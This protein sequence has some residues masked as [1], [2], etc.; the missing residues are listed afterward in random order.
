MSGSEYDHLFEARSPGADLKKRAIK[1][2]GFTISSRTF[3]YAVQTVGTIVMAR[4]LSPEDFGLA[5]MVMSFL[6]IF[7][8]FGIYGINDVIIQRQEI[9]HDQVSRLFWLN[10]LI[11]AG[12]TSLFAVLSP[13]IAWFYGEPQLKTLSIVFASAIFF[14]G[15][16]TVH[17]AILARTMAFSR[18]SLIYSIGAVSSTALGILAASQGFG[19]WSLAIRRISLAAVAAVCAWGFCKWRPSLSPRKDPVSSMVKFALHAYAYFI[20]DY[21]RKNLDKILVGRFFGKAVLG[22]YD[23]AYHLSSL[24]PN[25]L[26]HS[27]SSVVVSALSRMRDDPDRFRS[28]YAKAVSMLAFLSFPG[29]VLLTLLGREIILLLIG[30]Q[31]HE[32]G[33]LFTAMGPSIGLVVVYYTNNWLHISLGRADRLFKWSIYAFA[34]SVVFY[35]AGTA[36]SSIGVAV[37]YSALFYVLLIPALSYA[38]RP[39]NLGASFYLALLWKY[40]LAAFGAGLAYYAI[41]HVVGPSAAFYGQLSGAIRILLGAVAYAVLYLGLIVS[42]FRGLKPFKLLLS[43]SKDMVS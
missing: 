8:N 39:A 19:Y 33:R 9:G 4:L 11:M 26:T 14:E 3:G 23:R 17:V 7:Q 18:T 25:E 2:A 40:W 41:F 42:L 30:P 6:L 21:F 29:S 32:A 31:W 16:A 20:M 27:L 15:L 13:V 22:H 10:A 1:G 43:I 38:G 37:A 28:F 5:A 34:A 24:L 35:S 12:L 36:V